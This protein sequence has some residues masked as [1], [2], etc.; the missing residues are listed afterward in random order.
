MSLQLPIEWLHNHP[1]YLVAGDGP[2]SHAL[3]FVLGTVPI[4]LDHLATGPSPTRDG[5][6]PRVLGRLKSAFLVVPD[7]MP[8][9]EALRHHQR[10]WEWIERL[11]PDGEQHELAFFFV[12]PPCASPEYEGS[13]AVGLVVSEVDPATTGHAIWRS[14]SSLVDLFELMSRTHPLDAVSLCRRRASDSRRLALAQLRDAVDKGDPALGVDA[15]SQ[16]LAAFRGQE[17]DLDL[18]CRP[19]SHRHGNQLR[20]WLKRTVTAAVTPEEW[21]EYRLNIADWLLLETGRT[22]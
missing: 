7:E 8:A 16:V 18:F 17:Y 20:K 21:A 6:F 4:R 22:K 5:G 14:S 11:S 1:E 15:A 19:P 12:L 10:I 3:A 9:S 13:L 2:Y